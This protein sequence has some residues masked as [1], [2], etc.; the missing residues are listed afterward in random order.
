MHTLLIRLCGPMQSW[1]VQ[2]RFTVR[3]T[4][5]EPSKSGV[6]GLV[7]AALGID[8]ADDSALQPLVALRL[9][10]RTDRE[11]VLKMDY[12]TA[13]NVLKAGGGTKE[14]EVSRRYYLA[15]ACFLAGL[16]G[17]NLLLLQRI[18]TALRNPV[19]PLFLGRKAFVPAE[20]PFLPDGLMMETDLEV[21]LKSYPP[22]TYRISSQKARLTIEDPAGY[23]VR[24]DQPLSYSQRRFAPRRLTT[25]FMEWPAQSA[26]D[27]QSEIIS[28]EAT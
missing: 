26:D 11:G 8:R 24:S 7:C 21:A 3:D 9:G 16:A 18:Q 19:W 28:P 27:N 6:I 25:R 22:L 5:L 17:E 23:V 15:D 10:I 1:G 2:S 13:Q 12:H 20:I 4:G 14:T